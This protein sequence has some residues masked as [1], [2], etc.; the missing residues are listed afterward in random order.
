[1]STEDTT[2]STTRAA[3]APPSGPARRRA[4]HTPVRGHR[5]AAMPV[6]AAP[7]GRGPLRLRAEPDNPADPHA[8]AVWADGG[9]R[10]WRVGY[11]ERAVAVRLTDRLRRGEAPPVHF[12]GWWEEPGGRWY[13]PVVRIDGD[14]TDDAANTIRRGL[15]SLP[16]CRTVRLRAQ[17]SGRRPGP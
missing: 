8:V 14:T 5:F 10:P 4:F 7:L 2:P 9:T 13:R 6:G 15:R 12:A 11:L 3:T 17:V 1:M 16:P